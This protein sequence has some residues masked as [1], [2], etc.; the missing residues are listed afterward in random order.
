MKTAAPRPRLTWAEEEALETLIARILSAEEPPILRAV[1]FGSKARGDA[2]AAS[3][4][5]LLLICDLPPDER[6]EASRILARDARIV[7]NLTQLQIETWAV[8][9]ADLDEGWRTPMLVDAIEDGLTLWPRN[10]A[11]LRIPFTPADARFCA[12]C[13]LDW[14]EA[15]GPIVQRALTQ[16]RWA[17]AAQRA[18]DDITRLAAA[19]LFLNGE[20][21]HRRTTSL[22]LFAE[23]FIHTGYFPPEIL[24]ALHWAAA[25]YP[26]DGGR[27][28][29]RPPPTSTAIASAQSGFRLAALMAEEVV[30][31]I[32]ARTAE[33]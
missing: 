5:D 16:R 30:P 8:A 7:S 25:A 23:R 20:T 11:P 28:T 6:E 15:G 33:R 1:L 3:D 26:P 10:A 22:D 9:A 27:G 19:A 32:E 2:D 29:G 21:R 24:P 4:I 13:L 12:R 14:V 18:R 17:S 31:F